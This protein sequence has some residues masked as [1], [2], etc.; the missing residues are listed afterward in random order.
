MAKRIVIVGAG[1]AG[2]EAALHLNRKGKRDDVEITLV[3][4]NEYHTLLTEL[5]EVAG[6]RQAPETI[7]VPLADIFHDTRVKLVRDEVTGFDFDAKVVR[8]K[9]GDYSYD[10]CV[11]AMGSSPTY[12]GI[13]GMKEYAFTLWSYEEAMAIRSH[14]RDVF[15]RAAVESDAD[16]RRRLLTFVVGGAG[17]TGVEMAGELARWVKPLCREYGIDRKDVR[18]VLVDMLKRVLPNLDEKNSAKAHRYMEKKLGIEIRLET[19]ITE[20]KP[21][22]V[23]TAKGEIETRTMLWCAGI[24]CNDVAKQTDTEKIGGGKRIKVDEYCR[25]GQPGVYAV[26]DCGGLS[27][28]DGRPYLAM[29]ENALQ[30]AD[31]AAAN[32]LRDIRGQKPEK[33]TVKFH[34]TMVCIGRF[35][36][37]SDI[38][39]R[40]LPSWLS[41]LMKYFV[42]IHYLYEIGGFRTP[43]K[44]VKDELVH[45]EQDQTLLE[46]HWS[47]KSQAWWSAPLRLFLGFYWLYEG[48]VKVTEGWFNAP[49]LAEFMSMSRTYELADAVS[50]ATGGGAA[51]RIDNL[52]DLNL[53]V[54]QLIIG[55]A[56]KLVEGNTITTD[57][58]MKINV[59]HFGDFNLVPWLVQKLALSSQGGEMFFQI[60]ITLAEILVGLM[61]LGGVFT[62]AASALSVVL[63]ALFATSTGVYMDTWWIPFASVATMGAAGRAFGL[64]HYLLPWG[65]RVWDFFRKNRRWKFVFPTKR[66]K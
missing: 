54:I 32:I 6:H 39:G 36:G 27:G 65:A 42:N 5:H 7:R 20:M 16:E 49:K 56:S 28:E 3:D 50:H 60:A 62:F 8:G 34:G 18:L 45:V 1:Y 41:L 9:A 52:F 53:R 38:M 17:F 37:V 25:A 44:Y 66:G 26:G 14:V 13:P 31:G 19:A 51:L 63:V 29:V 23:V 21:D 35:F 22:R 46:K 10:Y 11:M 47:Y 15:A 24:S 64:D 59:F 12:F 58:F 43:A 4:R 2:V 61:L 33:V 30:T 55:N 48:I 40:R 57:V